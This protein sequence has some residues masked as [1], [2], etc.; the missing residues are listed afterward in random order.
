MLVKEE[1]IRGRHEPGIGAVLIGQS[2]LT[3]LCVLFIP[4]DLY[5]ETCWGQLGGFPGA[6]LM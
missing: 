6:H 2:Q 5:Q 3:D 4:L 1:A